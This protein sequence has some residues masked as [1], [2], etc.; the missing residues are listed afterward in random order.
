[1]NTACKR[2][3]RYISSASPAFFSWDHEYS[4]HQRHVQRHLCEYLSEQYG[5]THPE[6]YFRTLLQTPARFPRV[7]RARRIV[8]H[9]GRK[10]STVDRS[11][12]KMSRPMR[13]QEGNSTSVRQTQRE[14][15]CATGE[16]N[17]KRLSGKVPLPTVTVGPQRK[18]SIAKRLSEETLSLKSPNQTCSTVSAPDSG[19]CDDVITPKPSISFPKIHKA[20][21]HQI[22][23]PTQLDRQSVWTTQN[24]NSNSKFPSLDPHSTTSSQSIQR[25]KSK[26][27]NLRTASGGIQTKLR[28]NPFGSSLDDVTDDVMREYARRRRLTSR[29]YASRCL[30]L[31]TSFSERAW[32]EQVRQASLVATRGARKTLQGKPYLFLLT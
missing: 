31:A 7:G 20:S 18:L 27:E 6:T 10:H 29:E 26:T 19:D 24:P 25:L 28:D 5:G 13:I 23:H 14:P 15:Q 1:M 16:A 9:S 22:C 11:G 2:F 12:R 30:Q 17:D 32:L 21:V 8:S 4:V 3:C